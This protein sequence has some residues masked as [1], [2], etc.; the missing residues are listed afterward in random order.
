MRPAE[1]PFQYA[2]EDQRQKQQHH[3]RD[4]ETEKHVHP[5][6]SPHCADHL[7]GLAFCQVDALYTLPDSGSL[8]AFLMPLRHRSR[9]DLGPVAPPGTGGARRLPGSGNAETLLSRAR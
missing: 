4:A 1:Q 9:V 8:Y 5:A 6:V 7:G 2:V 3:T